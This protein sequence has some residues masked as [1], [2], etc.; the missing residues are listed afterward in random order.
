M[1]V[2]N[3]FVVQKFGEH[4]KIGKIVPSDTAW[5]TSPETPEVENCV[6]GYHVVQDDLVLHFFSNDNMFALFASPHTHHIHVQYLY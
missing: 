6:E 5:L 3:C 1:H 4:L 2:D